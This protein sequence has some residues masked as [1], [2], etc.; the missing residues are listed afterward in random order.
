MQSI[1][2]QVC[3]YRPDTDARAAVGTETSTLTLGQ[4]WEKSEDWALS[5]TKQREPEA[6]SPGD[7]Q[8]SLDK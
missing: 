7:T 1:E 2:S 8:L 5:V 4:T 6:H 3:A